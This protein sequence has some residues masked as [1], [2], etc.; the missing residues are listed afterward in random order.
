MASHGVSLHLLSALEGL[1]SGAKL[2]QISK[3]SKN[4]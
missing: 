2:M 1:F 3:N 4:F